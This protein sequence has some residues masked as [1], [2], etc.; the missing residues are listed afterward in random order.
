MNAG[1]PEPE[2][3]HRVPALSRAGRPCA[4]NAR[5]CRCPP[6]REGDSPD[7]KG[8]CED[9]QTRAEAAALGGRC[10]ERRPPLARRA[11]R[12]L[13][14]LGYHV[15]RR[16]NG[17]LDSQSP[18]RS[19]HPPL[20][21]PRHTATPVTRVTGP[22]Q[23][24][25]GSGKLQAERPL[26]IQFRTLPLPAPGDLRS[27]LAALP[28]GLPACRVRG[29]TLLGASLPAWEESRFL[30]RRLGRGARYA[31]VCLCV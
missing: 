30:S 9:R 1:L 22:V 28:A 25:T 2:R 12:R 29:R 15:R 3:P 8:P 18:R 13:G 23:P 6:S 31:G 5:T 20:E 21:V 14:L 16:P 27:G 11:K 24:L 10:R 17:Y 26:H 19:A 4:A 7:L